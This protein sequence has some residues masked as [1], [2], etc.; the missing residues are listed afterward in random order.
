MFLLNC[1]A[2]CL[3]AGTATRNGQ[4]G[5]GIESRRQQDF[6]YPSTPA[7]GPTQPRVQWVLRLSRG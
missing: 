7:L 4:D 3:R 6:P 5:P 1:L 2:M